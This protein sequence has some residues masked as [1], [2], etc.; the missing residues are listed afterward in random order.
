MSSRESNGVEG[1]EEEKEVKRK[2]QPLS[3]DKHKSLSAQ[4]IGQK[5]G[6]KELKEGAKEV[7]CVRRLSEASSDGNWYILCP[8]LQTTNIIGFFLQK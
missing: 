8:F 6:N 3:S 2:I 4:F 1:E 5:K 7:G